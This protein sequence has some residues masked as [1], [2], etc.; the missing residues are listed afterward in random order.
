MKVVVYDK[1]TKDVVAFYAEVAR[2]TDDGLFIVLTL[3]DTSQAL[4]YYSKE[5]YKIEIIG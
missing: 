1:K 4:G 5:A 3:V 2:V